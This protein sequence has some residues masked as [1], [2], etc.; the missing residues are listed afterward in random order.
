MKEINVCFDAETSRWTGGMLLISKSQEGPAAGRRDAARTLG[1]EWLGGGHR[2][3]TDCLRGW[4]LGF[5]LS[6][7]SGL[8]KEDEEFA[9]GG[10]RVHLDEEW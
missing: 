7:R 10:F 8:R 4:A 1:A 6:A 9:G 2:D 3:R 5:K